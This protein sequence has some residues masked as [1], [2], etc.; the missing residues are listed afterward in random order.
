[1]RA[2][3]KVVSTLR[4]QVPTREFIHNM[5]HVKGRVAENELCRLSPIILQS[6]AAM[7]TAV[8]RGARKQP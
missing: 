5:L 2:R 1:L 7:K 8:V 6:I 3:A 4:E